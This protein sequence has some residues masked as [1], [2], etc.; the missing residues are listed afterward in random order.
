MGEE[1]DR[2]NILLLG[3]GGG[4]HDGGQ[5]TDT[6]IIAS[7]QPS[8]KKV[9]LLSIPRDLAVPIEYAGWQKINSANAYGAAWY[10]EKKGAGPSLAT[11]TIEKITGIDIHYYVK[12]DFAG[13][14]KIINALGGIR[15]DVKEEFTDN[16][17]PDDNYGYEP[18][19][20]DAGW[21]NLNGESALKYVRSR[22]AANDEG[23]DFARARRQQDIIQALQ[24]RALALSTLLNPNKIL[25]LAD[26]VG[27]HVETD[28]QIW[29][30]FKVFD[31]IKQ[32]NAE[33][34]TQ[35][36]LST[37]EN[38]LLVP[39]TSEE[40]SYILRPRIGHGDFSEIALIAQHV[41]DEDPF[42]S[43]KKQEPAIISASIAIRNGTLIDGLATRTAQ[44]LLNLSFQIIEIGNAATRD[45]EKSVIYILSDKDLSEDVQLLRKELNANIAP[46]L[47]KN[48]ET[49]DADILIIVGEGS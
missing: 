25:S 19:H 4:N 9:A 17:Y 24:A 1:K 35:I 11:Q 18:I 12:L 22:H 26:I 45:Y 44:K 23:T 15:V 3:V 6:I 29:E 5:L 42:A 39:D 47:P 48:I 43:L 38:G 10:P 2:I 31:L 27:D 30:S 36:V 13:F 14:V 16:Q 37:E 8:E 46:S 34:I 33:N 21:Q 7:I 49:P 32:A 28:M 41:L 20:F 40:G